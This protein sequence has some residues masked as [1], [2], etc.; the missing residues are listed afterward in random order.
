[1]KPTFHHRLV[2]REFEDPSLYVRFIR[3]RRAILFDA[4]NISTL[5]PGDIQKITDI[6]ITHM[7]IDH[8]IGFDT[9][10]R[11]LLRRELPLRI[12][13][14]EGIIEGIEGKLRGY[15]WNLI[16]DYPAEIEVF[17][18]TKGIIRHASFYARNSFK[19]LDRDE[20]MFDGALLRESYFKVKTAIL[21]HGIPCLGFSL[22][23]D[24]HIN[25]DKDRLNDLGLPVGPWLSDFKK[26]LR[27]G[28]GYDRKITVSGHSLRL[29]DLIDIVRITKG[30]KISYVVDVS[31]EKDNIN[32]IIELIMGSDT[33]YCEAYFLHEDIERARERNHLTAR[34]AGEIARK[35]RVK[36]LVLIHFSPKYR[37]RRD[38]LI[39]EAMDVF[40]RLDL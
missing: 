25:I 12:Y 18:I 40:M 38:Q 37:D 34:L 33:L 39:R 23:E 9:I 32:K 5:N 13:G 19:R 6:F 16:R 1:M 17:S 30:Q 21:S 11:A 10:L 20:R 7:H 22:E 29:S 15:S 8:F 26:L 31:P 27:D 14:P 4:G 24:F 35:A 3:E 36:D 28:T 2:N